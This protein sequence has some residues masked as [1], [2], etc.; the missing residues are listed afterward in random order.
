MAVTGKIEQQQLTIEGIFVLYEGLVTLGVGS[1]VGL[2]QS[3]PHP[4]GI[5]GLLK[6]PGKGR[7]WHILPAAVAFVVLLRHNNSSVT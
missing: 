7:H 2:C 1:L 4:L 6:G 5:L 3:A